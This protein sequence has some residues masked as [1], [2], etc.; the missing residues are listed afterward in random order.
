MLKIQHNIFNKAC[1]TTII[2]MV[3]MSLFFVSCKD[4]DENLVPLRYDPEKVPTMITDSVTTLISDSGIT[5][6]KLIADEWQ[7]FDKA[8]E[9][10]WYFPRGIYL[11]RFTPDFNIEATVIADTAWFYNKKE[12]WKLKKNVHVENMKGELFDSEEL[13][14]DRKKE[15]VYSESFIVIKR[16]ET[17]IKGFGFESNQQMTDYRIFRPHDGRLP[18]TDNAP[19]DSLIVGVDTLNPVSPHGSMDQIDTIQTQ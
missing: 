17:E 1:I 2:A 5:R 16:G 3:V 19:A 12:L 7:V 9:P 13:F 10:Y 15:R 18:F 14:W 6:Y 8:G 4:K 11:E